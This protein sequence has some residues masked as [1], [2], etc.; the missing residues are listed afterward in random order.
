MV[1]CLLSA[2]AF[3]LYTIVY[4]LVAIAIARRF[5]YLFKCS[6][7]IHYLFSKTYQFYPTNTS[8]N[9]ALLVQC[10]AGLR[11]TIIDTSYGLLS[12]FFCPCDWHFNIVTRYCGIS[13]FGVLLKDMKTLYLYS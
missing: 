1:T 7:T 10:V 8:K 2:T 9:P 11:P 4:H 13:R 12:L 5:C 6:S 3:T